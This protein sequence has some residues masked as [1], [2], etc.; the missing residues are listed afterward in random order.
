M[1]CFKDDKGTL[2]T[3]LYI[4]FNHE[5]ESAS[6]CPQHLEDIFHMLRQVHYIPPAIDGKKIFTNELKDD[7]IKICRAI[8]NY[9][10]DIFAHHVSKRKGKKPGIWS[11]IE[12]DQTHFSHQQRFTLLYF[13]KTVETIIKIVNNAR[14]TKKLSTIFIKSLLTMDNI[15]SEHDDTATVTL[16]DHADTWLAVRA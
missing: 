6:R 10:F 14:T 16:L 15:L 11:P 4:I 12:L 5:D 3:Q 2:E 1:A 8:H 9:S 7:F 13:L